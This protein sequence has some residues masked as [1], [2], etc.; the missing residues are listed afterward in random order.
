MPAAL[1]VVGAEPIPG[2]RVARVWRATRDGAPVVVRQSPWFRTAEEV[3]YELTVLR[4]LRAAGLP[5]AGPVADAVVDGGTVWT[6]F[7][8]ADGSHASPADADAASMGALLADLHEATAA[9]VPTLGQR[10][11]WCR[12]DQFFTHPRAGGTL[13]LEE[14]LAD[15]EAKLGAPARRLGDF[16]RAVHERLVA[17]SCERLPQVVAHGD[18]GPH[19]VL[20]ERGGMVVLDW[21]F[22][23]LDLRAADIAIGSSFTRPEMARVGAYVG[24]YDAIAPLGADEVELLGDLR[25]AFHLNNLANQVCALWVNGIAIDAPLA[26]ISE[27]L[28]REQWWGPLLVEGAR[29]RSSRT[30]PPPIESDLDVANELADRAAVVASHFFTLGVVARLKDDSSPVT[31]ADQAVELALRASLAMLRP[32]DSILGE[33]MGATGTSSRTWVLDPIDGTS[34]FVRGDPSWFVNVALMDGDEVV[35]A[36]VDAPARSTRWEATAGGG[37][38]EIDAAGARR[39]LSMSTNGAVDGALVHHYPAAVAERLP[40]GVVVPDERSNLPLVELVRGEID[41]FYVDCC[42]IWD[43][44]PWVLLV[45]EAGGAFTDHEGGHS[46][47][48]RGGLYS[49]AP[50][51]EALRAAIRPTRST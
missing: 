25:R 1:G 33:E 30:A 36:V 15:F 8:W 23:H 42:Q 17:A 45:R 49:N 51:H 39:R 11:H 50:V 19:Q 38:F 29:R 10:P 46:P 2:G 35:V 14:A 24:A 3:D 18:F 32:D 48:K 27:R 40:A 37:T 26:V 47:A 12:V 5:V 44:A 28:E 16:A 31:D 21:D 34:S 9:L 22:C 6:A 13:T 7:E 4:A 20:V 43:H 41:A